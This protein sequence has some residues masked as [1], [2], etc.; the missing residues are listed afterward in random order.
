LLHPTLNDLKS[1]EISQFESYGFDCYSIMSLLSGKNHFIS[2]TKYY[3]ICFLTPII[4]IVILL[5]IHSENS[6]FWS[7]VSAILLHVQKMLIM[8]GILKVM[9]WQKGSTLSSHIYH[10][11]GM[12]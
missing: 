12:I 3:P 5:C 2:S 1:I 11:F 9:N 4:F 6:I 7:I 10:P 8:T